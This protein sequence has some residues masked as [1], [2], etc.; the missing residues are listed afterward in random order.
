[1]D[2]LKLICP[3]CRGPESGAGGQHYSGNKPPLISGSPI[4]GGKAD[5]EKPED[6]NEDA[7]NQHKVHVNSVS[8]FY[9]ISC[10]LYSKCINS[11]VSS[12][13]KSNAQISVTTYRTRAILGR[14]L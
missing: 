10:H 1:M 9:R 6:S 5:N 13:N 14:G 11:K 7:L 12:L 8:A 2:I 3:I 4:S